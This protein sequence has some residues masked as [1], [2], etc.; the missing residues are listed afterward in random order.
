MALLRDEGYETRGAYRGKDVLDVVRDFAPHAVLL[1]IGMPDINGCEAAR[2]IRRRYGERGPM[3]IAVTGWKK[4]ADKL[5]AEMAASAITSQSPTIRR[6]C[7]A[8]SSRSRRAE[9][10]TGHFPA[11]SAGTTL[12][13]QGEQWNEA[14]GSFSTSDSRRLVP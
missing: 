8:C 5:L 3:L 6:L 13:T 14:G 4:S 12:A 10:P 11:R 7:C 9:S 1:D 2:Q